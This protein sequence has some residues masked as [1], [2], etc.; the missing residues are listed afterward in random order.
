[1]YT[2]GTCTGA[3]TF[4]K[5]KVVV[6]TVIHTMLYSIASDVARN[7]K[8]VKLYHNFTQNYLFPE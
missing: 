4:S 8:V 7:C 5:S 2:H 3:T 6:A 1:M